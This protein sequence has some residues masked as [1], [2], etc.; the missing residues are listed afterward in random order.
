VAAPL[1]VASPSQCDLPRLFAPQYGP[2]IGYFLGVSKKVLRCK[3]ANVP[4]LDR[5]ICMI[6]RLVHMA[7][8]ALVAGVVSAPA[9]DPGTL[10][11]TPLPPL[12]NPD[13][14]KTLAKELFARNATPVPGIAR[15]IGTYNNGCLAGAVELPITGPGWQVMRVSRNRYWGNPSLVD[16][17]KRLAESAK[18]IGWSG[19]LVGDMSQPRGGPMF[20]GHTSHQI[21]LDVDIWFTPAPDHELSKEER[22]FNLAQNM[23]AEDRRDVDPKVWTHAHTKV[24]RAAAED[25]VVTRIF[26][27]PAIKKAL[28]REAGADR[29]W[30]A[31][32]RPWWYH[33]HHF[34]VRL[35]CPAES[36]ECKEQPLPRADE[37]CGEELAYW[38][39]KAQLVPKQEPAAQPPKHPITLTGMPPACRQVVKA[40]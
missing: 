12:A 14:P 19:I 15:S 10:N 5:R 22:E 26:V 39:K 3:E 24:V 25:D 6:R 30:L 9:Q 32:I 17:I 11:P 8:V 18:K 35:A 27:N 37:G 4:T 38:L 31:K 1:T 29:G 13:S 2:R 20:T 33:E 34:H 21:G 40:P 23:V 16:F 36:A 7:C 28:C